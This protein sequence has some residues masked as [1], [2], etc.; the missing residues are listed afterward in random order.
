MNR[1]YFAVADL[2]EGLAGEQADLLLANIQADVLLPHSDP[3]VM[4]VKPGGTIALSGILSK[5]IEAVRKH[6]AERFAALR[7]EDAVSIHS[8]TDGEWADLCIQLR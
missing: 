4:G 1:P 5:E 7:P 8:R 3:V 2:Q 6:Y